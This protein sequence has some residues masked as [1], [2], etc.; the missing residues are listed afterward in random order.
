MVDKVFYS[1]IIDKETQ[2]DAAAAL[3]NDNKRAVNEIIDELDD[4]GTASTRDTGTAANNVPLNSDLGT[5]STKDTGTAPGQIP[6][7][8]DLGSAAYVNTG[9]GAGEVPTN[10]DLGEY[11]YLSPTLTTFNP[12]ARIDGSEPPSYTTREGTI[13]DVADNLKFVEVYLS[14]TPNTTGTFVIE[15]PFAPITSPVLNCILIEGSAVSDVSAY[16]GDFAGSY[17]IAFRDTNTSPTDLTSGTSVN[18]QVSGM[19]PV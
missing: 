14:F 5:A 11:A 12:V 18:V 19:I 3:I 15:L 10:G 13:I 2:G 4:L 8:D 1:E 6:T 16:A 17:L 9:T 7:S